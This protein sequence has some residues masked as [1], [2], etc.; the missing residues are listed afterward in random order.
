ML[1]TS[2]FVPTLISY[3]YVT[4]DLIK[5]ISLLFLWVLVISSRLA[6]INVKY[7]SF[8]WNLSIL[9]G[10]YGTTYLLSRDFTSW[11]YVF[12]FLY[13]YETFLLLFAND[14]S[15]L[16]YLP[17]KN[18]MFAVKKCLYSKI[19]RTCFLTFKHLIMSI[20]FFVFTFLCIPSA[21]LW[22]FQ[23]VLYMSNDISKNPGPQFQN[24]CFNFMS[25]NLN[26]LA[27]DNFHR[28]SLIEAHNSF[29][30]YD[31]ISICETSLNDLVELPE[32]LLHEYTFVSANNPANTRRGG[33]GLFYKNS[34]PIVIRNDLS[35]DGSIVVELKLGR[36]KIFF[37]ILYRSPAVDHNSPNPSLLV[38]F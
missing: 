16:L 36:K 28:V 9:L 24:N 18:T 35:F 37:T 19:H 13:L 12:S 4:V 29:Y 26:S 10:R 17:E 8:Q 6:C 25:W 30:N 1:V 11:A 34:L 14:K 3:T 27:K 32:T 21:T 33:V 22:Y 23:R 15:L 5:I 2:R 20:V 7:V 38:R 31:L